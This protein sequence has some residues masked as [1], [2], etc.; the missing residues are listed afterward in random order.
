LNFWHSV[1][2]S[3]ARRLEGLRSGCF[4]VPPSS[5]LQRIPLK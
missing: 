1:L 4:M 2:V 3:G 5:R